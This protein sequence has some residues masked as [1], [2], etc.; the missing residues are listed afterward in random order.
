PP[1]P[2]AIFSGLQK[3]VYLGWAS[4]T[5]LERK[6]LGTSNAPAAA[7][8]RATGLRRGQGGNHGEV[9]PPCTTSRIASPE[10]KLCYFPQLTTAYVFVR[11]LLYQRPSKVRLTNSNTSS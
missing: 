6:S 3:I 11:H 10:K 5:N 1:R 8:L 2:V 7:N 9:P 4:R